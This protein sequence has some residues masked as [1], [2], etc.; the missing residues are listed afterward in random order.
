MLPSIEQTSPN[1]NRSQKV[2]F[3]NTPNKMRNSQSQVMRPSLSTGRVAMS[4]NA[5]F[6]SNRP[7]P[8]RKNDFT[9]SFDNFTE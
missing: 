4:L 1:I 2:L 8:E 5:D 9:V 3:I 6:D 7:V